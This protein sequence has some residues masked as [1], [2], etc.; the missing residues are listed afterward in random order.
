[1]RFFEDFIEELLKEGHQVDIATNEDPKRGGYPVPEKYE[2]LGCR[3]YHIDIQRTPFSGDTFKAIKEIRE[4]VSREEYDI[5]HCHT[6][7]AG[8]CTRLACKNLRRERK[9]TGHPLR[10]FYTAHGFHFYKGSPKK[11]WIIYYPAEWLCAHYTDTLITINK[12]DYGLAKSK[13][14]GLGKSSLFSGCRV[15]YIP[16][17]GIDVDKFANTVVDKAAKRKE[18]GV[19]EDAFLLLSVGE[20]NENK[21]HQIVLKALG[22]LKEDGTLEE[23]NIHYAIAG[24]GDQ[25]E[26]LESLAKNL[27]I[28]D[29]FH[30]LGQRS[31]CP[32]LYKVADV[33]VFPSIRE[34]LGLAALEGMAAGLPLICADNRGTRDF[35]QN[36]VNAIVCKCDDVD[37][38]AKAIL[39]DRFCKPSGMN[40]FSRKESTLKQRKLYDQQQ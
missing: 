27:G 1:M 16:G 7:V 2:K 34:G 17:V 10:V 26:N 37:A 29:R 4:L 24:E 39:C 21:N 8:V 38:F 32:Q 9:N 31:D 13:F 40:R 6:P 18:I 36:G 33:F 12:E 35:V 22:K 20:L 11:N 3:V 5:V 25:K 30:L 23:K 19:P 28:E 14:E 15:E